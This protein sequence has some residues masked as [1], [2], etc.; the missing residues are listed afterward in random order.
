MLALVAAAALAF[1]P[2][3]AEITSNWSVGYADPCCPPR[4]SRIVLDR[5]GPGWRQ[6]E[7]DRLAAALFRPPVR[8]FDPDRL[9]FPVAELD[10]I[11]YQYVNTDRLGFPCAWAWPDV[12]RWT[13]RQ[14]ARFLAAVHEP[15]AVRATAL[16]VQAVSWT[17]DYPKVQVELRD[18]G[19]RRIM[20]SSARIIPLMLPWNVV[21]GD[22]AVKTYDPE[23]P[24][25]LRPLLV[26]NFNQE[27]VSDGSFEE[28]LVAGIA[29]LQA[30]SNEKAAHRRP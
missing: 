16:A 4:M 13:A 25:A 14:R 11:A 17:D 2:I 8:T 26:G 5:D 27:R 23:I 1:T 7:I 28:C 10:M 29:M 19:G 6:P 9:R 24:H 20:A 15:G 12:R 3:H 30:A 22:G 21:S 18:A